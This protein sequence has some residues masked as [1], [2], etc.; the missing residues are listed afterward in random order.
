MVASYI[1]FV[2]ERLDIGLDYGAVGGPVFN[3]EIINSGN[4]TE[5]RNCTR[6][7]PL[8]RWQLGNR[9]IY[10][11]DDKGINEVEYLRAFH[12]A[13]KGSKQG[14]RYKDWTDYFGVNQH[15]GTTDGITTQW[16][17]TKRYYAGS[18]FVYRPIIKPVEGTVNMYLDGNSITY[19]LINY[20]TGVISF[21]VPPAPGQ[22]ITADF[23]FDVPVIYI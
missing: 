1:D 15:I 11:G 7:F 5:Q 20:S 23:E 10:E 21:L 3:T 14:F 22:V 4:E 17:L 18:Y 9:L 8:G 12:A 6:W 13:R 19:P 16:Q 2:E